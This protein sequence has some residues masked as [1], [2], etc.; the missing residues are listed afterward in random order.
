[1]T[2][3]S[4]VRDT[5]RDEVELTQLHA[6]IAD[7]SAWAA[8]VL[9]VKMRPVTA[10]ELARAAGVNKLNPRQRV[11]AFDACV[12]GYAVFTDAARRCRL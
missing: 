5:V 1:M 2:A 11:K 10:G 4:K 7:G 6:D 9:A 12:D 8:L 3:T